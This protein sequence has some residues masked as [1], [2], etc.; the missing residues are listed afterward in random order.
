MRKFI[1]IAILIIASIS[2][3]YAQNYTK[4]G[5]TYKSEKTIKQS[6]ERETGFTWE[7]SKGIQ[8]PIYMGPSGSCYI[9]KISKKSGNEYKQYLG[10]EISAD[11]CKQLGVEYKS[12]K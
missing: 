6:S 7:D 12:T 1:L 5:K 9:K 10:A 3:S 2:A 11:I 4:D 8:Y